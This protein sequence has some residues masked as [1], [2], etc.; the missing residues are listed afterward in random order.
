M[1]AKKTT[2][3]GS[4]SKDQKSSA[5]PAEDT[6]T[7]A[8][9]AVVAEPASDQTDELDSAVSEQADSV[10][11]DI[12][13]STQD[14]TPKSD[15]TRELSGDDTVEGSE[16]SQDTTTDTFTDTVSDER[17]ADTTSDTENEVIES[18]QERV[19][20][21]VVETRSVFIPAVF[22]GLVAGMVGLAFGASDQLS[23]ILPESMQR[24][25]TA[26]VTA[27]DISALRDQIAELEAQLAQTPD[28]PDLSAIEAQ[29]AQGLSDQAEAAAAADAS[30]SDRIDALGTQLT[31]LAQA[32]L[33]ASVSDEAI[34]AYEAELAAVQSALAQQRAEVEDMIAEAAQMEAEASE[35]AR[36]AQ[37]QAAVTRLL[38]ALDTSGPFSAEVTELQSLGV[39]V[40]DAL[41]SAS[42]G[43]TSLG[44]LQA[45]FPE[46]ARDA[47]AAARDVEGGS[48]GLSGFLQRQLGARS[49]TPREGDDPDAVLSRAEAALTQGDLAQTL[50]ELNALPDVA[51]APLSDWM[52]AAQERQAALAAADD[53]A[54]SLA[55]N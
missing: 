1:A 12:S 20:E 46:L 39:T 27:E 19:V 11:E 15:D 2:S 33:E 55:R 6:L 53:L 38:A 22:G 25:A 41:S 21:R 54:Q 18:A 3:T 17:D 14:D 31:E 51:K 13:E 9:E 7:P 42:D 35:N 5:D 26:E 10:A 4:K 16:G 24:S 37:A 32:P 49:V 30:L 36:I 50:A 44:E 48:E 47:L 34:A 23:A 40:P 8:T 45:S 28:A 52:A 43:L 29:I